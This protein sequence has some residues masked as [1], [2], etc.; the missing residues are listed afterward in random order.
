MMFSGSF[1]VSSC[2]HFHWG[3]N[4][5]VSVLSGVQGVGYYLCGVNRKLPVISLPNLPA[6]FSHSHMYISEM[7]FCLRVR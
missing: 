6:S 7:L 4:E 5:K 1:T 3:H 2:L